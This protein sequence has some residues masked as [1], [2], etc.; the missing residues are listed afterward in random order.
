MQRGAWSYDAA[1]RRRITRLEGAPISGE[2]SVRVAARTPSMLVLDV[3]MSAG[4]SSSSHTHTSD[5]A[6][7]LITGRVRAVIAGVETVV[8]P[9]DGF[10]HPPGVE[11]HVEALE[12]SRWI[13][14]KSP[15]D[16]PWE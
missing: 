9:G 4:S 12:D 15:P 16:Q 6:G 5:S 11:H 1:P 2:V 10:H 14:I 8:E 3:E 13:E 7:M